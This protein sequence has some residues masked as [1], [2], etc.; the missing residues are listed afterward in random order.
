MVASG[1]RWL[2]AGIPSSPARWFKQFVSRFSAIG[3][4]LRQRTPLQPD[5]SL[6]QADWPE[7]ANNL[8]KS[9]C[10]LWSTYQNVRNLNQTTVVGDQTTAGEVAR[11]KSPAEPKGHMILRMMRPGSAGPGIRE[12]GVSEPKALTKPIAP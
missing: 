4:P 1:G 11:A 8:T 3:R 9:A 10:R 2:P 6:T 5:W 7:I 12:I